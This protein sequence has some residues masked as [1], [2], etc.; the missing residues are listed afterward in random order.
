MHPSACIFL[1][2]FLKVGALVVE[3]KVAPKSDEITRGLYLVDL[4][5]FGAVIDEWEPR[6]HILRK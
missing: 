2:R 1:T 5:V 3:A 4:V 6:A